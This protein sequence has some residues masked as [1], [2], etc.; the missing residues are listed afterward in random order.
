MVDTS[1]YLTYY[2]STHSKVGECNE[3]V[4]SRSDTIAGNTTDLYAVKE[5]KK[6]MNMVIEIP[7]VKRVDI[8]I[9][10][11]PTMKNAVQR[12]NLFSGGGCVPPLWGLGIWYRIFGNSNSEDALKLAEKMRETKIPCAVFGFEPGWHSHSYSCSYKWDKARFK[13]SQVM[14]DKLN[15]MEYK[16]NLWEHVFIHPLLIF[17]ER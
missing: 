4:E 14:I 9:F 16:I 11:G 5:T 7:S 8:Y 13:D 15:K 2:C 17:M 6:Q 1:S 10:E 12:Y 3:E